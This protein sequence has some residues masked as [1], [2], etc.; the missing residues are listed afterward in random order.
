MNL[1]RFNGDR[2]GL[3]EGDTVFD[4]SS[5]LSEIAQ[6]AWPYP[7]GDPLFIHLDKVLDKA[8]RLRP[9][10]TCQ[11]LADVAL[12]SP[13]TAPTKIMAAPVNYRAHVA[14]ANDPAI[15]AGVH[16]KSLEGVEKPT[17]QFGLFLKASSSLVGP[18]EGISLVMKER[19]TDPEIELVVVIGKGGRDIAERDAFD[20]VAGYALG[21]DTTVRGAEDR[22]YRKSADSYS[23][24]GPW[25]TTKDA[26]A[27]PSDLTI[28][29]DINGQR[30][31]SSST[32]L[33]LV[34]IPELIAMA[35]RMY[36]LHPGD[37][38]YTGTPEGVS[39]IRSGDTLRAGGTGL[40]E[41]TVAVR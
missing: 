9:S 7:P 12:F 2:L 41:M 18:S 31:Q 29:L 20:H 24:L 27:D 28:W 5:A 8:R 23:L 34:K 30:R 10:A 32:G 38:I 4:V 22:S 19:R 39:Q 40:G 14:D 15:D 3:V 35:S 17:E 16:A 25:F 21:L 6:P 36:A 33:L 13:V 26:I 37:L 11:R 1:C